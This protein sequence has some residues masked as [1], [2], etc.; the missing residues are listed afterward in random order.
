MDE[1]IFKEIA[2]EIKG[3]N[4]QAIK[5]IS[6]G[7]LDEAE[8][9]CQKALDTTR[10]FSYYDGM[11]M[12]YFNLANLEA[13]RDDLL[14]AMAYGVLCGEMHEKAQT[15]ME[16]HCKLMGN[17]AMAA[18]KKG[19]GFEREGKLKEALEY[20]FAS[21]P[22]VEEKYSQAITKEIELIERVLNNGQ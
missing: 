16:R 9:L 10:T 6:Q 17:L 8:T 15:D 2:N 22:F 7:K 3:L 20:Y 19:M 14:K 12:C 11:A 4:N 21:L 5:L 13:I 18:M 1:A